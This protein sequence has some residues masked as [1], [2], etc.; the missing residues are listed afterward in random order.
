M[1]STSSTQEAN[2]MF[3]QSRENRWKYI[4]DEATE[5]PQQVIDA[6]GLV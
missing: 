6:G 5:K 1:S 4:I 3:P 2:L